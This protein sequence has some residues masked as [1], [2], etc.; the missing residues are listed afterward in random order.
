MTLKALPPEAAPRWEVNSS[1]QVCFHLAGAEGRKERSV[2]VAR[3]LPTDPPPI[4][5]TVALCGLGEILQ[6]QFVFDRTQ[7]LV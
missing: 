1:L 4:P 3:E 6:A 5:W 7:I 2:Q